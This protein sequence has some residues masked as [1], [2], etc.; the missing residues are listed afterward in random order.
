MEENKV[1]NVFVFLPNTLK[2]EKLGLL[3]GFSVRHSDYVALFVLN[4][5]LQTITSDCIGYVSENSPE[6][7]TTFTK[8]CEWI[9]INASTS[10]IRLNNI[11]VDD[12]YNTTCIIYDYDIFSKSEALDVYYRNYGD[13]FQTL[14]NALQQRKLKSKIETRQFSRINFLMIYAVAV[15]L[16]L[17][18]KV[19]N[20]FYILC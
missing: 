5:E 8:D 7:L 3:E 9:H 6:K 20:I 19:L 12:T 14:I 1:N 15:Y 4:D 10:E 17:S 2:S 11:R 18:L 16:G 13:C